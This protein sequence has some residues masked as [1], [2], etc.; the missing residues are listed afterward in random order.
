M[1]GAQGIEIQRQ[2]DR[3]RGRSVGLG[4]E[5]SPRGGGIT[6]HSCFQLGF[7]FV[8]KLDKEPDP[9]ANWPITQLMVSLMELIQQ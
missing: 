7:V 9:H 6:A 5:A 8:R 4:Y 2:K 3:R 1:E